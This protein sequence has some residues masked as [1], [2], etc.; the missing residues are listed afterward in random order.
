MG[1]T[2]KQ[3]LD[4]CQRELEDI[5][6]FYQA[7]FIN[8]RGTTSDTDEYYTEVVAEFVCDNIERFKQD[9]PMIT[10]KASYKTASHIGKVPTSNR[11]EETI[12]IKMF[13]QSDKEGSIYPFIGKI[14]DYQTPLKSTKE[15]VAGKV[16]LLAYDG[17]TL[18]ILELKKPDSTETMLR[19]VLEGY[20]YL[21]TVNNKKLLLNFSLP[22]DTLVTASPLV[23]YGGEQHQEMRELEIGKRP[24]LKKLMELLESKPYYVSENANEEY[25]IVEE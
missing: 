5:K 2:R 12:A 18:H 10:R 17:H 14:I 6:T 3:I 19:C 8:Y 4:E 22:A 15:D 9:I 23:F 11:E 1:Y 7:K 16:D 20:T 21:Q 13:N 24:H 25:E